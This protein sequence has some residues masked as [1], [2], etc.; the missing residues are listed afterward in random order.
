VTQRGQKLPS[1]GRFYEDHPNLV[2]SKRDPHEITR[3]EGSATG[4]RRPLCPIIECSF[5]FLA[6]GT[7]TRHRKS[8]R[9]AHTPQLR[10]LRAKLSS[11]EEWWLI[12]APRFG[13]PMSQI[14]KGYIFFGSQTRRVASLIPAKLKCLDCKRRNPTPSILRLA[15]SHR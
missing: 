13:R 15:A 8:S 11:G 10:T 14:G 3:C 7:E 6:S 1:K 5:T 9:T 2:R 4:Y 12:S